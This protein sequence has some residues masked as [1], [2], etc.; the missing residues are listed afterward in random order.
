MNAITSS[1]SVLYGNDYRGMSAVSRRFAEIRARFAPPSQLVPVNTQSSYLTFRSHGDTLSNAERRALNESRAL[2][3]FRRKEREDSKSGKGITPYPVYVATYENGETCRYSFWSAKGKPLDFA[4]GYNAALIMGRAKPV[5]GHV[6][7]EG[8]TLPDP[9]FTN[10]P[11]PTHAPAPA[12]ETPA[13]RLSAIVAAYKR[14][15]ME[16]VKALLAKES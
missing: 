11:A 6:E 4:A 7:A 14:N 16:Q 12:R 13:K 3:P 8:A 2:L 9:F 15:D 1:V 5:M 10:A